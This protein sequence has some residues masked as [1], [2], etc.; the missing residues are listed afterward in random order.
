MDFF[1]A[2]SV[3]KTLDVLADEFEGLQYDFGKSEDD[4]FYTDPPF[5]HLAQFAEEYD[6]DFERFVDDVEKA[7][8]TLVHIPP[9]EEESAEPVSAH[10]LHMMTALRAK[11]K[12]FDIVVMLDVVDGVWP[13][14]NAE[15]KEQLESERRVFYV[16]FTRA[17][18]R[19]VFLTDNQQDSSPYIRELGLE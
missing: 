16:A 17:K 18:E 19:V 13:H 10:P 11:G 7:K 9:F 12:E 14:K 15:S 8:E 1:L 2:P 5:K 4:I 3:S 6:D